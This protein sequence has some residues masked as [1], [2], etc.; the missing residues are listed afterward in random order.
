[1]H[2]AFWAALFLYIHCFIADIDKQA[3]PI[4][5]DVPLASS[6]MSGHLDG[7][8]VAGFW[9]LWCKCW[10]LWCK[11]CKWWPSCR[12]LSPAPGAPG[13]PNPPPPP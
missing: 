4:G 6:I 5:Q 7:R 3:H 9:W 10:P 8:G 13:A 12:L 11:W 2:S 1:M